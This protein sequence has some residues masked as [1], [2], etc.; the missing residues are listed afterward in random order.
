MES[1][2]PAARQ[3]VL[4]WNSLSQP[5]SLHIQS[6]ALQEALEKE[7]YWT[8]YL[9]G[10]KALTTVIGETGYKAVVLE[11]MYNNAPSAQRQMIHQ[12]RYQHLD[13]R[14]EELYEVISHLI[15]I[16]YDFEELYTP[17][18]FGEDGTALRNRVE[19]ALADEKFKPFTEFLF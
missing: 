19:R 10:L 4:F 2:E 8:Q 7:E 3:I 16:I 13:W 6:N 12:F 14:W 15:Y 5:G 9:D 11:K 1:W 18:V 17:G